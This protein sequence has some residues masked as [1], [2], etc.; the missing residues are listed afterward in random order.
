MKKIKWKLLG[1]AIVVVT[2]LLGGVG[3]V[4]GGITYAFIYHPRI[5][6]VVFLF[7]AFCFLVRGMYK[8]LVESED[9]LKDLEES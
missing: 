4:G 1:L 6:L 9:E 7:A 5:V 2:G 8:L 3:F